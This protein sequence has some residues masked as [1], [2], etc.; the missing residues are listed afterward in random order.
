MPDCAVVVFY[1]YITVIYVRN[2]G[3]IYSLD[4]GNKYLYSFIV[5]P[6]LV[7]DIVNFLF[8]IVFELAARI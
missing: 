4:I 3:R 6:A 2:V 5:Y 7:V 8:D 1:Y